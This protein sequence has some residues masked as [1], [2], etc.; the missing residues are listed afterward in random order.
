MELKRC[1]TASSQA[2][3]APTG[4][5]PPFAG[6]QVKLGQAIIT[7]QPSSKPSIDQLAHCHEHRQPRALRFEPWRPSMDC[8]F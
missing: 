4:Q 1:L 3:D 2:G 5:Q 8:S 7:L 6:H